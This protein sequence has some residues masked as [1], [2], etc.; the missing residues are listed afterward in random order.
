VA[1]EPET[2][3]LIETYVPQLDERTAVTISSRLREA[4][5]E[6][7][8][9][10]VTLRCRGSFALVEEETYLCLV[11]APDRECVLLLNQR[12]ALASDHVAEIATIDALSDT[13]R[14]V[15]FS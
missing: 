6:L 10:G 1:R 11:D 7:E 13:D 9:E 8:Q 4:M 2:T 14:T 15:G 5:R 12:A 3:F